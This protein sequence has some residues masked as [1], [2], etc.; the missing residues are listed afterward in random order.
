MTYGRNLETAFAASDRIAPA[1]L[2]VS[3]ARQ[4]PLDRLPGV[5]TNWALRGSRRAGAVLRSH[6]GARQ[7]DAVFYHT[8]TV[9]LLAPLTARHTPVVISLDATPANFDTI[10][11]Y[12]QHRARPDGTAERT[13][14]AVYRRVFGSASALTTWSQWAKD[15]LRND[16]SVD[17][18]RVTVIAPGIDLTLFPFGTVPRSSKPDRPVRILFVGGD[19]D[20]KGGPLLLECMRAGLA[21]H[22]E[23]HLVTKQPVAPTP[24]VHVHADLG[25]NDPRLIALYRDADI[26][27]LPTYADCLSV[28]AGEAMAAGLPV[29]TTTVGAQAEAVRDGSSGVLIP[30]GDAAALGRALRRLAADPALRRAMGREGRAIAATYFDARANARRIADV[31]YDGSDRWRRHR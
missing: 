31:I 4:G 12:Y 23:L 24:R 30:P 5:G 17:P 28:V 3:F 21:E 2:P 20:R 6:G 10:G 9:S 7:F 19:F 1:W 14:R 25:P 16:Y 29:V 11:H 8:Q 26:F 13:K 18:D 22:C 15:S 27:A